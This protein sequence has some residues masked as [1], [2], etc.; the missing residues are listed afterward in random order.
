[1]KHYIKE[2][3]THRGLTQVQLAEKMQISRSY[4]TMIEKGDRR[5][6]QNF[7]EAAATA[8]ETTPADLIAHPPGAAQAI[9]SLLSG[10]SEEER[11]RIE[12][13]IRALIATDA[14]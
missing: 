11:H 14:R 4:Y 5:Y 8:L 10:V 1:M 6:D 3:R 2:W 13:A 12:A 9:E 7:L